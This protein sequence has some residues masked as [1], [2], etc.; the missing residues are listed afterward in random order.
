LISS[1]P[2]RSA[3]GMESGGIIRVTVLVVQRKGSGPISL[4]AFLA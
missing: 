3:C 1:R 2:S 4:L